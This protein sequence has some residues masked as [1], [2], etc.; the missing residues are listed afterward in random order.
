MKPGSDVRFALRALASTPAFTVVGIVS[1]A[2]GI[3]A[4]TA[5]FSV[6]HSTLLSKL[7]FE[8]AERLIDFGENQ[9]C[10][11]NTGLSPGEYL[12]YKREN[13]TLSGIAAMAWRNPTLTG[14]SRALS[15]KGHAVTSN[16]FDVLGAHAEQGRLMSGAIDTLASGERVAVISDGLWKS[17]FGG[18]PGVVGREIRLD[19]LPFKLIGVLAPRQEYPANIQIWFS[20]RIEV[21]EYEELGPPATNIGSEYG[22]HWMKCLARLKPG[23]SIAEAQADMSGIARRIDRAH[24][25]AGHIAVLRPLQGVL[26]QQVRPA[27]TVLGAAVFLVLLIA[28]ANLAGLLLA[29][30]NSRTRELS[31]RLALGAGRARVIRLLLSESILLALSGGVA[32]TGLALGSL[33]LLN[34]YSP[35]ELPTALQPHLDAAV[36]LFCFGI[37]MLAAVMSG[38]VPALTASQIDLQNGLKEGAKST[39]SS[40]SQRLRRGIVA[41]EVSLCLVLLIGSLMLLKSFVNLLNVEPGFSAN[42]VMSAS[43]YLPPATYKTGAQMVSFWDQLLQR[44]RAIPG[45]ESAGYSSD[46]PANGIG[47]NGDFEADSQPVTKGHEPFAS[48]LYVSPETIG[49]FKI[50]LISGRD[51]SD[52]DRPG[53]PPV[54]LINRRLADKEFPHMNPIGH[55]IRAGDDSPWETIVGV[56]GNVKWY[57]LDGSPS[58]DI[59]R[60]Y[61]QVGE[62]PGQRLIFRVAPGTTVT[63]TQIETIVRSLDPNVPVAELRPVQT[64]LDE[65]LGARRF[66]LALLSVFAGVAVLLAS[67]GLYAILAYSVQQR[68]REIGVRVAVGATNLDIIGMVLRECLAIAGVGIAGGVIGSLWTSSILRSMLFSVSQADIEAYTGAVVLVLILAIGASLFPAIR[69]ARVDPL[70]ALRYE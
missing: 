22:N 55:R 24:D 47:S 56:V 9:P 29:R 70:T 19:G 38:L 2:L 15:L 41:G 1:L 62:L 66:L 68:R 63:L 58:M 18:D 13:R 60:S 5:I 12:D 35:Y 49:T 21:P 6:I 67:L 27:I 40:H 17:A 54:V 16:F 28:C 43:V 11:D 3:G 30:A 46:I 39:G 37:S 50:P 61:A 20:S 53:S 51:L 25:K 32:G 33:K 10:C 52:R 69:A 26:V 65:S 57:G 23:V 8:H 59:Y 4:N 14:A 44:V 64:Y 36:L 45:I 42:R 7:P 31:I 34:R 48:H